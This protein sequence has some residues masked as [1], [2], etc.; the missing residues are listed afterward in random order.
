MESPDAP[1]VRADVTLVEHGYQI[2]VFI[3][4]KPAGSSCRDF[5][6][7]YEV[8]KM[9][10]IVAALFIDVMREAEQSAKHSIDD[11]NW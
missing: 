9:S 10:A 1:H 4:G 8:D 6:G 2:D 11:G 7:D 5:G 3:D